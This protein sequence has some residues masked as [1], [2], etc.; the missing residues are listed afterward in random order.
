MKWLVDTMGID[1]LRARILKERKFLRASRDWPGGI[2]EHVARARRRAGRRRRRSPPTGTN[3]RA[4]RSG[5]SV[6]SATSAGRKPTS[7][8]ASRRAPSARYAYCRLGDITTEQFRALA[9]IQRDFCLDVRITNRQNFVLRDL[10]EADLPRPVRPARRDRHGRTGRRA[11]KDVVSCP[12]ADT[13]NLAVTQSRGLAADIDRA[14][15]DAGP[16]RRRRRARST[17]PAARTRAASTTSPTSASSASNGAPTAAPRPATRCCSAAR[18]GDMEVEFGQKAVEAAGEGGRPKRSCGSS[19]GSPNEREAGET[20]AQWLARSGGAAK[21]VGATSR[22][23]TTSPPPTRR[24][25]STSTSTRPVP[26]SPRSATGSAPRHDRAVAES[27][28][29]D[30]IRPDG[31]ST[32]DVDL[33]RA[34]RGVG[35]TRAQARVRRGAVGMGALRHAASCSRRR[36]RTACCSTSR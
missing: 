32:A 12:G 28:P 6:R 20:F 22:T 18:L 27:S 9:D 10:T 16:R 26:T 25:T 29:I 8:A 13:C 5:C 15:E 11:R 36:S 19:G 24:P 33:A 21:A 17:S 35:R 31:R 7:C 2:P 30:T 23:S 1:E 3:E 14:L 4:S 34:R